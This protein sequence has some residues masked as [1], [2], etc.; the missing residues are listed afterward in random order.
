ME[1][2][3]DASLINSGR[4]ASARTR[5]SKRETPEFQSRSMHMWEKIDIGRMGRRSIWPAFSHDQP[6]NQLTKEARDCRF[7]IPHGSL[8]RQR[9]SW[10]Q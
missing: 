9:L 1:D 10:T 2:C 6:A 5:G 8:I 3:R 4:R 7:V